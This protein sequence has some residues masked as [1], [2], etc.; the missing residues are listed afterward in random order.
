VAHLWEITLPNSQSRMTD[1]TLWQ[2][3]HAAT[4]LQEQAVPRPHTPILSILSE[5]PQRL[6]VE[7]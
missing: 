5:L 1:F 6:L 3:S 4:N 2:R 7:K